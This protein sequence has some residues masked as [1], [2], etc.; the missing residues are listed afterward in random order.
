MVSTSNFLPSQTWSALSTKSS[1]E[2]CVHRL[3]RF[4][5]VG[6]VTKPS[7]FWKGL[8]FF[9]FGVDRGWSSVVMCFFEIRIFLEN[10]RKFHLILI[11]R[12]VLLDK[13]LLLSDGMIV[14]VINRWLH[15]MITVSMTQDAH[16]SIRIHP[17]IPGEKETHR[18]T[19]NTK[20]P[21]AVGLLASHNP[22]HLDSLG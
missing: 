9:S 3:Y 15:G 10:S 20:K 16:H 12:K 8:F 6:N 7:Y 14:I 1:S 17:A 18:G 2:V 21:T 5:K 22:T 19:K 4:T 11:G 13:L